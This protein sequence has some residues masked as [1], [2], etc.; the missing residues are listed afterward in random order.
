M[1]LALEMFGIGLAAVTI[2][3]MLLVGPA[4]ADWLSARTYTEKLIHEQA[5]A[6]EA[7]MHQ[8]GGALSMITSKYKAKVDN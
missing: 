5:K 7:A 6:G 3:C 8:L 2:Y 4:L 1:I